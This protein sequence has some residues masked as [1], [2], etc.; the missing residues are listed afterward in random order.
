MG[1]INPIASD[2]AG[3]GDALVAGKSGVRRA[4][5]HDVDRYATKIAAEV[6]LPDVAAYMPK[7]MARRLERFVV[8]GHIAAVQALRD[9]GLAR[10]DID[11]EPHRFGAIIGTGDAG[12]AG[13]FRICRK[14]DAG[15]ADAISPFYVPGVIPNTPSSYFAIEHGLQGPNFS[16]SSACASSNHAIGTAAAM[17]RMGLA[18]VMFAGGTEAVVNDSGFAGFGVMYAL[19]CRNDAPEAASRPFDRARDGFVLGEGAG[20]ICLEELSHARRRGAPIQAELLGFGFSCDAHDLVAP[21]PEGRGAALAMSHA[22]RDARLAPEGI[23][24]VNAHGTSTVL[25]D[26]TE[27]RA[28]AA[29]FGA[30]AERVPVHSTKSMIGHLIGAAGGTEAIAAILAIQ[31]GLI[32]PSINVDE[33]DPEIRLDIVANVAR[34]RRV[35]TV[36]SN[37]FGFGGENAVVILGRFEG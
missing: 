26:L 11:R 34:E 19:S 3:F 4:R 24:L 36:L 37:S 31:R 33:Q 20:V 10:S 13:H 28:I 27:A 14:I 15:G 25:G 17:I 12:N 29:V 7:K 18:D 16:V 8:L 2:V 9:S 35:R 6:D 32:H 30:A 21:H 23:D 1:T 5:N 22:L